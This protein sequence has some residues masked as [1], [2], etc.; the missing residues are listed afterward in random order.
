MEKLKLEDTLACAIL[1]SHVHVHSQFEKPSLL[2][3]QPS[4][5]LITAGAPPHTRRKRAYTHSLRPFM[6]P[7]HPI[8]MCTRALLLTT[9]AMQLPHTFS[10]TRATKPRM[11]AHKQVCLQAAITEA[12]WPR[13]PFGNEHTR[14]PT[15]MQAG[16]G[17][18][19]GQPQLFWRT[20]QV[21]LSVSGVHTKRQHSITVNYKHAFRHSHRMKCKHTLLC[22]HPPSQQF[23]LP[24]LRSTYLTSIHKWYARKKIKSLYY[25]VY[26]AYLNS[27]QRHQMQSANQ[28]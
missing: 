27:T 2:S 28:P 10:A 19:M 12:R 5:T 13:G 20:Q 26:A 8:P 3:S 9:H 7:E 24:Y 18:M 11:N 4:H 25:H 1:S 14:E 21:P 16:A 15:C 22:T 17:C 23:Y 6:S